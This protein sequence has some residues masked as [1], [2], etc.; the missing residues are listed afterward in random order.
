MIH[1]TTLWRL[2]GAVYRPKELDAVR[3]QDKDG[4]EV[5][6]IRRSASFAVL[7][8]AYVRCGRSL[9]DLTDCPRP[10]LYDN[11]QEVLHVRW[12]LE[13]FGLDPKHPLAR[14]PLVVSPEPTL[15]GCEARWLHVCAQKDLVRK[16][17]EAACGEF[18]LQI[19]GLD[20]P[21]KRYE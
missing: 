14:S 11:W 7:H 13:S 4:R 20:P 1:K 18:N 17:T 15:E 10:R 6:G 2:L 9:Y 5:F 8:D 21:G 12:C 19:V 3:T 16:V